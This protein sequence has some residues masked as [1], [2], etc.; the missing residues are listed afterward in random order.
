M[1]EVD[2]WRAKCPRDSLG[3]VDALRALIREAGPDLAEGIKWN[4]PNF[5]QEGEDRITLGLER[6]GSV[7]AVLHRGAAKRA[8]ALAFEDRAGLAKWPSP[9]RGV[10]KF[11]SAEAVN[12][13][14]AELVDLFSRWIEA[15]K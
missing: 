9:D 3:T 11:A 1:S 6:D 14:R 2:A 8:S 13:M 7:R 5:A 4:A 10:L 15:T 12:R